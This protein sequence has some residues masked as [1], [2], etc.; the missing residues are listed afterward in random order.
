MKEFE[1]QPRET[2]FAVIRRKSTAAL[3]KVIKVI[4]SKRGNV[5]RSEEMCMYPCEAFTKAS[6]MF[7]CMQLLPVNATNLV[8][9]QS[10][11]A[12]DKAKKH[13]HPDFVMPGKESERKARENFTRYE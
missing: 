9:E 2:G 6:C 10:R 4:D 12:A 5:E 1:N 13:G 3:G 11:R 8:K 7:Y